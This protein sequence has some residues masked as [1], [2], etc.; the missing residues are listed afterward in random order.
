MKKEKALTA[1]NFWMSIA[2][3]FIV[4]SI[5]AIFIVKPVMTPLAWIG[6]AFIAFVVAMLIRVL[7]AVITREN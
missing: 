5:I 1:R 3:S 6:F 4:N 2:I 7:L